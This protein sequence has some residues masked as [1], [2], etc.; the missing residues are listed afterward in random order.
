[1]NKEKLHS[2]SKF[3]LNAKL[4]FSEIILIIIM[5]KCIKRLQTM[6]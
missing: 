4:T 2:N 3:T 1:M 6:N 5:I